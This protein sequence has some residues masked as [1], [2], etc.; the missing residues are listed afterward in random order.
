MRSASP[1][2]TSGVL[3]RQTT[4]RRHGP[5]TRRGTAATSSTVCGASTNAMSAPAASAALARRTA[6]SKPSTARLSV[7]AMTMKSGSRFGAGHVDGAEAGLR[8][9]SSRYAIIG[10]GR[11][12]QAAAPQQVP[13]LASSAH[14]L[15]H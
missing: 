6:S 3:P 2:A 11:D 15:L 9:R 10:A 4:L 1:N 12:Y 14:D 13:G 5:L 8:D 7:R